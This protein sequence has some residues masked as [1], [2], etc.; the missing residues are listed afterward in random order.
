MNK[1]ARKSSWLQ[2]IV[3]FIA[4]IVPVIILSGCG[5]SNNGS[6]SSNGSSLSGAGSVSGTLTDSNGSPIAGATVV[7]GSDSPTALT[8]PDGQFTLSNVPAGSVT[9]NAIMPGFET[10]T[11]A[12]DVSNNAATTVSAPIELPDLDDVDD[13]PRITDVVLTVNGSTVAVAATINPGSDGDAVTDAR[14]E[15]VGYGTGSRMTA[16]GST[17]SATIT[18]PATFVGPS[19]LV[20]VFAI[21]AKRRVGAD[22]ATA[23]VPGASGSGGFGASTFTG[24][25]AGG[26]EFHRAAFGDADR[27]GDRRMANVSLSISGS[28]VSGS[29]A[30]I[31]L[32]KYIPAASWG[33]TTTSFTGALTLID[34]NLG[35]YEMTSTFNPTPTR[36]VDLTVIG[37]LDSATGPANFVGYME[38]VI[39]DTSPQ[40]V[41]TVVRGRVHLLSN[42]T[43]SAAD[44]DGDWVWSEFTK[45]CQSCSANF[46]Y[47]PPFQYNS[48]FTSSGG[49]ISSG[50]D[51]LG[52]TLSTSTAFTVDPNL[53]I[54]TG[55]LTSADNSTI[56][57]SGLIGPKKKHVFGLFNVA[58]SGQT[59]YG[60]LW[61]NSIA[62]PPHFATSDFGQKEFDGSSGTAIWRGFYYVSAGPDPAG[63]TCFISLRTKPDGSVVGGKIKSL[64]L[65]ACPSVSFSSGSL[66]FANTTDGGIDGS[67]VG[68]AAAFTLAPSASRNASMG[69]EKARLVGDF[70]LNVTGGTDT[71]FFFL[72]RTFI[73]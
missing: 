66:A 3:S 44:L 47:R 37:K 36:T 63:T 60:P 27:V 39:T 31:T 40:N 28:A 13:A 38:A 8:G 29:Y 9:L 43:W 7:A 18:L 30:D 33:V 53:G 64:P 24:S 68:G 46:T 35:I 22:A 67:A 32:E 6:S 69:V 61:G 11:F 56:T 23:A 48:S 71:G 15:L 10:N 20:E 54:F 51:T 70:S 58:L 73:E 21:D 1:K 49:T 50:M 26:A 62:S 57:V 4:I 19:A 45:R 16:N 25:W 72:Q 5:G 52:N 65:M 34:A 14:A 12:V 41:T 2:S 42:L 17:Y 55:A 59:A